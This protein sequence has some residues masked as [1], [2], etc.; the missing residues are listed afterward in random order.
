MFVGSGMAGAPGWAGCA[1]VLDGSAV[2]GPAS[3]FPGV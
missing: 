3:V 1:A 2:I